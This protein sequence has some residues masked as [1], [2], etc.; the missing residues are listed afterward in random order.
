MDKLN[1]KTSEK[2]KNVVIVTAYDWLIGRSADHLFTLPGSSLSG[3]LK[4][5][6]TNTQQQAPPPTHQ[7]LPGLPAPPLE[8]CDASSESSD[9]II[10]QDQT[11]PLGEV[12]P[13]SWSYDSQ[14]EEREAEPES[15]GKNKS[16]PLLLDELVF[17]NQQVGKHQDAAAVDG[18]DEE[19]HTHSPWMLQLDSDSD[20]DGVG[21]NLNTETMLTTP[22]S[23][24]G[25]VLAP[26]PLLQMKVGGAKVAS[27]GNM[28]REGTVAG[29][30][31]GQGHGGVAWRPMPRLV[32]L[33][34]RGNAPS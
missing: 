31:E 33:G 23:P 16:L 7:L 1:Q 29:V 14:T 11:P 22:G 2:Y 15:R 4:L 28:E 19:G 20:T 27:P 5:I 24:K 17:L 10:H 18:A 30:E 6:Q 26:P 25:G 3:V 13:A 9:R 8:V 21:P 34:L 12:R 32:P